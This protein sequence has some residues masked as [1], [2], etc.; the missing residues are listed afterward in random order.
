MQNENSELPI[1]VGNWVLTI[2]ALGVPLLNV[3]LILYWAI[4][5]NAHASKRNFAR[6]VIIVFV[7]IFAIYIAFGAILYSQFAHVGY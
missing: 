5:K 6:A 4:S 1:S 2:L 7:V 3:V